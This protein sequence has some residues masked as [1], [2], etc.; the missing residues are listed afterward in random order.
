MGTGFLRN[1]IERKS[2]LL[3]EFFALP[4]PNKKTPLVGSVARTFLWL[5][6]LMVHLLA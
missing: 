6:A 1:T 4:V 2:R 3:A 5:C